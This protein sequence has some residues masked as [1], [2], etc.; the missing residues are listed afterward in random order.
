L[1]KA[2]RR[3]LRQCEQV[4]AI[5]WQIPTEAFTRSLRETINRFFPELS[6]EARQVL[7][8]RFNHLRCHP[9]NT[10]SERHTHRL[11]SLGFGRLGLSL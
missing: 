3:F 4:I 11:P 10:A 2:W 7:E 5:D 8:T 9:K 6:P 1:V